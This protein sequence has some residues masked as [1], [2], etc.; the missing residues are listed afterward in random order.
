MSGA[1]VVAAL[2]LEARTLGVLTRRADGLSSIGDGTLIAVSGIGTVA[3]ASAARA[4]V[5]AGAT[6][7]V[8]WGLAG[9]LDPALPA[10]TICIPHVVIAS[11]GPTFTTDPDWRELLGAAIGARY[12]VVEGSLLTSPK[13]IAD[14]AAKAAAFRDTGAA[15]VDMESS[16]IAEIAVARRLPFVAIRAIVD[17]AGDSLPGAVVAAS[18]GGPLRIS[19]LL[20][21]LAR[22]PADI[23]RVIRLSARYRAASRALKAVADTGALAPLAFATTSKTRIA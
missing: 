19:Q 7:L 17:A 13:A 15:A 14:A 18:R 3:A 12:R 4:L 5:E 8:S 2:E 11:D 22:A 10:G 9:G 20:L 21:E 16:G 1:G 23:G 6:A